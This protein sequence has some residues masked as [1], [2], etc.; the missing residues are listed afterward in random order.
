M[1]KLLL[2]IPTLLCACDDAQQATHTPAPPTDVPDQKAVIVHTDKAEYQQGEVVKLW[3]KN[4]LDAPLWYAREAVCGRAFW[5]ALDCE[6]LDLAPGL[7]RLGNTTV[8][9]QT[10]W[11]RPGLAGR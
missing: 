10:A 5:L 7:V 2:L 9:F 8:R 4:N 1:Q 11:S 6:M 3:V